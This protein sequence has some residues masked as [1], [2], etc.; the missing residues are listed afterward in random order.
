MKIYYEYMDFYRLT[1]INT[2]YF[3]REGGFARLCR[4]LGKDLN[5]PWDQED[6][7]RFSSALLRFTEVFEERGG[8]KLSITRGTAS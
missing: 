5:T 4:L 1:G 6:R 3:S 2:V 8:G 7:S